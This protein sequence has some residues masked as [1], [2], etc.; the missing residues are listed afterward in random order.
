MIKIVEHP[1]ISHYLGIMRD[2]KA[3]S[4]QFRFAAERIALALAYESTRDL[5]LA[6]YEIDTPL[7]ST[8]GEKLTE[9]LVLAPVLR[10][11]SIL[12]KPFLE[13]YPDSSIGF[14]GLKRDEITFNCEE[15]F[16]SAPQLTPKD[17]IFVLEVMIATGG[18]ICSALGRLQLEGVSDFTIISIISA[19]EGIERVLSEFPGCKIYT[20]ALDRELNS[21][22]YILPGLGDAG[23]RL[24]GV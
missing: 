6:R 17:K 5:K 7:E 1:L 4:S 9:R 22:K 12:L 24:C 8:Q 15:Y 18:S 19:P 21:N 10:A 23:D 14:I 3:T 20:A 13:L 2:K 16:F 11:G